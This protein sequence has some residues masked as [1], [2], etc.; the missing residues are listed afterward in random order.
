MECILQL[1]LKYPIDVKPS[2]KAE[3]IAMFISKSLLEKNVTS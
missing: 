2:S 3:K 1:T